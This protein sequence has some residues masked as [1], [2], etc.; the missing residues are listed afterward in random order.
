MKSLAEISHLE[1]LIQSVICKFLLKEDTKSDVFSGVDNNIDEL[2]AG[3]LQG[4]KKK[5]VKSK[6][7]TFFFFPSTLSSM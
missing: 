6:K 2:H 1:V 7:T 4:R 5:E 3:G